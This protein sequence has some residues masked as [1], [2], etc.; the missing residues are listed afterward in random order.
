MNVFCI[1]ILTHTCPTDCKR[2]MPFK[3]CEL[4]NAKTSIVV[5]IKQSTQSFQEMISTTNNALWIGS[6]MY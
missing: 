5:I 3:F 1:N 6:S 4:T 2:N